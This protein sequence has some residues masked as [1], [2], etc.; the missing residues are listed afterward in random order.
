MEP[1]KIKIFLA[2]DHRM[3]REG[4]RALLE[5]EETMVV[6][7]EANNGQEVLL[8]LK[9][10]YPDILVLDIDMPFVSGK[11]IILQLS[12]E[13]PSLP[14]LVLTSHDNEQ[15]IMHMMKNGAK[16]YL[17]KSC[18]K[19][20]LVTAIKMV[21]AGNTYMSNEV[22]SKLIHAIENK[23][24]EAEKKANIPLTEREIEILQLVATGM[25][26][27]EI[28]EQLFISHRTVDTHRR[29][30]MTKLD[31]HNAAALTNYAAK[32]DLLAK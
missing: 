32:N 5:V 15:Y 29:N 31:L 13:F 20:E 1:K 3:F 11:D 22:S 12:T 23:D 7:D 6:I 14:I 16:G 30:I 2:D 24:K 21:S 17:L 18:R 28:G 4:I 8:G 10:N 9:K 19:D 26:N 25:T 27:H